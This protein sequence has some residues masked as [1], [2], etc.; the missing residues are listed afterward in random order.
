LNDVVEHYSRGGQGHPNTDP[1]IQP[2][3][4]SAGEK[5]DL[6]A[7]LESLTDDAFVNDA[8]FAP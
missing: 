1:T 7:F 3:G 2:L 4:L 5:A 6:V 8:R